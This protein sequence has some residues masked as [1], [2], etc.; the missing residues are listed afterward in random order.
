MTQRMCL[1]TP[2]DR[3][4]LYGKRYCRAC[5]AM[6]DECDR[7][8]ATIISQSTEIAALQR[9]IH[10]DASTGKDAL[11]GTTAGAR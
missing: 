3:P 6:A 11:K 5:A 4:A 7:L 8:R 10:G 1:N 9:L 2:C